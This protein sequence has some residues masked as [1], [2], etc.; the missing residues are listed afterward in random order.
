MRFEVKCKQLDELGRGICYVQNRKVVCQG[1]LEGERALIEIDKNNPLVFLIYLPILAG[2]IY[3]KRS[4]RLS[5]QYN[6]R[7]KPEASKILLAE[8]SFSGFSQI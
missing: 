6:T 1:L 4:S 5:P 8:K 3:L 2:F 7:Q